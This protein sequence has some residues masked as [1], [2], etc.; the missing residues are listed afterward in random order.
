M[1]AAEF[2]R[3]ILSLWGG[4]W[5]ER[6]P[7]EFDTTIS[8]LDRWANGHAAVPGPAGRLLER[9][10]EIEAAKAKNA[11]HVRA[12]KRRRRAKAEASE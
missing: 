11:A 1:T 3:G 6:A 2:K 8:S 9:L 10:L 4:T 7:L 12:Y 5:R